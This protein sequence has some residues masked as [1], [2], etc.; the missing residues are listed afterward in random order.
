MRKYDARKRK[1]S[2]QDAAH[3]RSSITKVAKPKRIKRVDFWNEIPTLSKEKESVVA[4]HL[5]ELRKECSLPTKN[6]NVGKMNQLMISSF[7]FRR[8]EILTNLI[9]VKKLVQKCPPLKTVS[10]VS[11]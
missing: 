11:F 2:S 7:E 1:I 6:Q 3:E 4:E 5:V 8:I 9:P 10:G